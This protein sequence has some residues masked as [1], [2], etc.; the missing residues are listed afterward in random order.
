MGAP[1][2][3][4]D[5]GQDVRYAWRQ[6]VRSPGFA[7]LL[8]GTLATGIGATAVIVGAIDRALLRDP[9]GIRAST[10]VVKL[11]FTDDAAASATRERRSS[12]SSFHDAANYPMLVALR[13]NA[14]AFTAV[15][16]FW[17]TSM[18][19]RTGDESV[20]ISATLV[21]PEF[22][23]A[24]GADAALGRFF[25]APTLD[26]AIGS[27]RG[28]PLAVL[29]HGFWARHYGGN[30]KIIGTTA[31]I[32]SMNYTIVGVA[33]EGFRGIESDAPD[34]WL[35]LEVA[36][37][38]V[39]PV[40]LDDGGSL[41]LKL[42]GRLRSDDV[43]AASGQATNVLRSIWGAGDSAMR[44]A[45]ATLAPGRA[46]D[47]PRNLNIIMWAGMMSAL[48]LMIACA[49]CANLLLARTYVR[50]SE[51]AV[52]VALGADSSRLIRQSLTEIAVLVTIAGVVAITLGMAGSAALAR[53]MSGRG[54]STL[55]DLRILMIG[56]AIL[57]ATA[58]LVGVVPL[59]QSW[60]FTS[61]KLLQSGRGF[62]S[63]GGVRVRNGLLVLQA[64][65]CMTLLTVAGLFSLSFSRIGG[66][67]LGVD[68]DRTY[69]VRYISRPA[70]G[71]ATRAIW[72]EASRRVIAIPGIARAG[73]AEGDPNRS[74]FAVAPYTRSTPQ[75]LLWPLDGHWEPA[76]ATGVDTGFF[77][78]LGSS[79]LAGR[80]FDA[81]DARGSARVA[82]INQPL[83]E[84]LFSK[85][86][87]LG[88]CFYLDS[89]SPDC[90]EVVGVLN[91][92]WRRSIL[93]RRNLVV[94][95]PLA[96]SPPGRGYPSS[97]YLSVSDNG[98]AALPAVR[99]MMQQLA[100]DMGAVRISRMRD[101]VE[102]ELKPW[103][104]AAAAFSALA[105]LAL[106]IACVG[107]YA[108]VTFTA[109]ERKVE[110]A[111]RIALGARALDVIAALGG[112][113]LAAVTGGL[114]L[115]ALLALGGQRWIGALLFQTSGSEPLIIG[116]AA[117]LLMLV[118]LSAII[119]PA[120]LLRR[121]NIASVL[122]NLSA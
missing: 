51:L 68:L 57:V 48:V 25:L 7:A 98:G 50:R 108:V 77:R 21:S 18:T 100:P 103:R 92:F 104:L 49:N 85:G 35:P 73:L 69:V 95:F 64:A 33:A 31:R 94:Y 44:V 56:V 66:L 83:A 30:V 84:M 45:L 40:S 93:E 29:S 13:R 15:A 60:R 109:A 107:L 52:R 17:R 42:V 67:D 75:S 106:L 90:I 81:R 78:T 12:R 5:L 79:S 22:F 37:S 46:P 23:A 122:R 39:L 24:L 119:G 72:T 111:T 96:Q 63:T 113:T 53:V 36:S 9:P 11:L 118:A 89:R 55:L 117:T 34:V 19:L 120:V 28:L 121:A 8:I 80:D 62:G 14:P 47:R 38:D 54:D 97:L 110:M 70:S 115:G 41:W 101:L 76:Y 16:G 65:F 86:D 116:L 58:A 88:Q 2:W 112:G 3:R 4:A 32:G 26:S 87:A 10:R 43:E 91:G 74:G 105:L 1:H 99:Q 6:L 82:I 114:I 20:P 27:E 71:S 61:G 102:P 59:L